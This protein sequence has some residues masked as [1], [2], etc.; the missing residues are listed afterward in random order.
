[1]KA[2]FSASQQGYPLKDAFILD[3]GSTT[4][5]CNDLSRIEDVRPSTPG[6]YIWAGSSKVW[7][8]GYG[9]V[10]LTTEGSQDKQALHIVNVAWCPDFL[11]SL[12]SF[13]LL[14]RQGIWWDNREDP[15]S[16]RRWDGTI[17][18]ILSER[19]GQW[20]IEDTTPFDSAFHVRMNRTKRSPQRAT[21][22]LW[23]KRLGHPGPS[24]IEHLIQQSEGVRIKGITTVQ[25]D[26]CG[27]SKSKRQIRR[28]LRLNDEG[29]GERIA[30]DFHEYEADSFTKEKSQ[31]LITCRNSRYVWDFYFKDNRPARSIIR[32]LALFIQFMKKQFNITVKV[33]ET[34]NE[35]VTVKQEV[36]KWCTSLSIRLEPS[37]PDTQAQNGGAERSGGVIKEKARAIRL[38]ANLP[39]ELWPE[40]TRAAV[41]LYNRTP[42]YPNKWKSPYEIFFTRAAATNGIVTGP[43]RPNQAH[44]RAYGCK[45]FA[46]TDDT[47][48][49]KSRLQRLDPKAWIGY[50]VG[51]QSTNIYRI[52]IPSMA[53]VISTRDVVFNEDTIFNG[54]TEDL[55]DNLMHNTLEE[56][57]T[58][59]RTVE[60]PGTQS[61]QPE[62]ETFY[63]DDT[64][65]EESPRTQKTRYHQGRKVVEAYLTPPPTPPPVALLVQGEVNNEDMTN[66]SN[67]S[68]SMTNPWA[69]AFM[70]G[71]ES[72][73]IA[74]KWASFLDQL[75]LVKRKESPLKEAELEKLQEHLEGLYM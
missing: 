65:Q 23:H 25:C 50:L 67:Q 7:I 71:T 47:H 59:V 38:D 9:A 10:T 14:R 51:Y 41:Y 52:W 64:T 44:L 33:I 6:D 28:A 68:T 18:A 29:P 43:R 55:M 20:I 60:L 12:V 36:E 24:A 40:I 70:A 45:A 46:M 69:A 2:A 58:W 66:M 56:I 27:R 73:H 4:H 34:D 5:I 26:A 32:L 8:R 42:N 48:R 13:R 17:I 39:W 37:A 31:M 61:Q 15:T 11:C 1:M 21:A 35:I 57:A 63:E 22:M 53:K 74:N 3:S 19:H 75:G 49:G 62:T 30:I 54:K 72:G 16:L